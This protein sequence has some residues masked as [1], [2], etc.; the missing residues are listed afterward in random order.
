MLGSDIVSAARLVLGDPN[1]TRWADTEFALWIT[2]GCRY[3]GLV[4][5]DSCAVNASMNLAAGSKQSIAGLSPAGLRLLDVVRAVA[6]GAAIRLV[7]REELDTHEPNWHAATQA[8]PTN[9]VYDN[10]DPTTFYVYPPATAN[11]QV[12]IIYSR[13]PVAVTSGTLG[14]QVLTPGDEYFDPLLNYVLF[15]AYGKDADDAHNMTLSAAYLAACQAAL[16]VKTGADA[17]FS[18]DL[19]SPGAAMQAGPSVGGV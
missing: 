2:V 1:G 17:A 4:R 16:G 5:P 13:A 6:T 11:T 7:D 12:E 15:R 19:N 14:S 9:Y 18:P 10:R 3:V 8:V